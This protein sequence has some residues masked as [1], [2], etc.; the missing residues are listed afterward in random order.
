MLLTGCVTRL[1]KLIHGSPGDPPSALQHTD[2]TDP[3]PG[4]HQP[5][6]PGSYPA[7]PLQKDL[8]PSGPHFDGMYRNDITSCLAGLNDITSCVVGLSP[9]VTWVGETG[10]MG[11]KHRVPLPATELGDTTLVTAKTG[12]DQYSP[13]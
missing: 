11:R 4:A 1:I 10:A 7:E 9:R 5:L 3:L 8:E 2:Q 6:V 12:R 13:V